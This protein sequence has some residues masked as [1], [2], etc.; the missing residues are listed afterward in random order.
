[1]YDPAAVGFFDLAH[2]GAF[3]RATKG[4]LEDG[5]CAEVAQLPPRS[6]IVVA[7]DDMSRLS[8]QFAAALLSPLPLPVLVADSLPL[9]AGPLDVVLVASSKSGGPIEQALIDA[10]RRGCPTVLIAPPHGPLR[11][12]APEH[13]YLVPVPPTAVGGAPS[14]V[15]ATIYTLVARLRHPD[16][17]VGEYLDFAAQAVDDELIAVSPNR[18]DMLNE[19]HQLREW[20]E[21]GRVIHTGVQGAGM[22]LAELVAAS[23][24]SHGIVCGALE[25]SELH[26]SLPKIDV[27]TTDIFYDPFEDDGEAVIPLRIVVW[28]QR[29]SSLPNSRVV[30]A[31]NG[32]LTLE[33]WLRLMVRGLAAP[34]S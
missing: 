33:N 27:S 10:D 9:F 1:M 25:L 15:I 13:T 28:A 6:L 16:Q 21:Q 11:E 19:A 34:V 18:D 4:L 8:A 14:C 23:W 26:V 29:E 2:E 22:A 3:I 31:E 30:T 12:E 17:T 32:E 20:A 24:N 7:G 5:V